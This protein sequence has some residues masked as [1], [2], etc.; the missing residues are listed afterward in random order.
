[1]RDP[2]ENSCAHRNDVVSALVCAGAV[3]LIIIENRP[4][5]YEENAN[6]GKVINSV[7]FQ[8]HDVLNGRALK[9]IVHE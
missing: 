7:S 3:G 8:L 1:M 5:Q 6:E 4:D 9:G 2:E